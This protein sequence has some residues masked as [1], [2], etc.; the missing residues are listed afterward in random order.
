MS[1]KNKVQFM[2]DKVTVYGPKVDGGLTVK[3]ETGEQEQNS[4]ARLLTVS[5]GVGLRVTVEVVEDV[6]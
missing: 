4:V 1:D 2:A 3:F 5:R 6:V